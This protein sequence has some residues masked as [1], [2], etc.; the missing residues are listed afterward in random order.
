MKNSSSCFVRLLLRCKEINP[1]NDLEYQCWL[2]IWVKYLLWNI[3]HWIS[4]KHVCDV[5]LQFSRYIH[6][7]EKPFKCHDCGKG[8]CQSRTLAVHR[9]LHKQVSDKTAV[10]LCTRR[11]HITLVYYHIYHCYNISFITMRCLNDGYYGSW[12]LVKLSCSLTDGSR[13][14]SSQRHQRW[15]LVTIKVYFGTF[16]VLLGENTLG[17]NKWGNSEINLFCE[18]KECALNQQKNEMLWF[19]N[20]S[21]VFIVVTETYWYNSFPF[22][23][24]FASNEMLYINPSLIVRNFA[25]VE[26][27]RRRLYDFYEMIQVSL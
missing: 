8:F 27:K 15:G 16:V 17:A 25:I 19:L 18:E 14:P 21:R 11:S 1:E 7:K 24:K 9:T 26:Q 3:F 6:S 20:N 4:L 5:F 22:F 12:K 13:S 10:E 2:I 23:V